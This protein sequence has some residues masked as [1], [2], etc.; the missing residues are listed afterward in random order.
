MSNT[1]LIKGIN[2]FQNYYV[3]PVPHRQEE[4]EF[5]RTKN[6]SLT[7]DIAPISYQE[8]LDRMTYNQVFALTQQFPDHINIIANSD[9]FFEIS[10][11]KKV[12]NLFS[13]HPNRKRLCFAL[14]RWDITPDWQAE[15]MNRA[16]SQDTW[17]FYGAVPHIPE[18][19]FYV[20]GVAGCDNKIAYLLALAG[21]ELVNPSVDVVTYHLHN[22]NI[23]NYIVN[24]RV[25]DQIPPPY[26]V[27]PPCTMR[28]IMA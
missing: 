7:L 26:R 27:I 12:F 22:S 18:A 4:I 21:Y 19:D 3:D 8:I 23:R 15:F 24:G 20:G 16:D 10:E 2:I 14:T 25:K 11:L 6:R 17:I 9:I 1:A 5:C 28:E 13:K